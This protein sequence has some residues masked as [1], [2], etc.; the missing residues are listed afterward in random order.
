MFAVPECYPFAKSGNTHTARLPSFAAQPVDPA[1]FSRRRRSGP[2][3]GAAAACP[4]RQGRVRRVMHSTPQNAHATRHAY[5]S[6]AGRFRPRFSGLAGPFWR[7]GHG[8]NSGQQ[9]PAPA[10][11]RPGGV[12]ILEPLWE[13]PAGTQT[14][15]RRTGWKL[16]Q[17]RCTRQGLVRVSESNTKYGGQR[18]ITGVGAAPVIEPTIGE[19][20]GI[21]KPKNFVPAVDRKLRPAVHRATIYWRRRIALSGLT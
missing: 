14:H 17:V 4:S 1:C 6:F 19:S 9:S 8:P 21:P 7:S 18:G 5:A 16:G 2:S 13:R 11:R 3:A 12:V 15:S 20:S 10:A